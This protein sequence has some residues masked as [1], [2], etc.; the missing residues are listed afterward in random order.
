M[1]AKKQNVK[2]RQPIDGAELAAEEDRRSRGEVNAR[3]F[4]NGK[5]LKRSNRVAAIGL[6]TTDE[7]RK[8][9]DRLRLMT[10]KSYAEIFEAAL[11][12]F[13]EKW[14]EENQ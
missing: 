11:D 7:K 9:F 3:G 2:Y 6:K 5:R 14:K 8:Q 12:A 13:E 10:A 4:L 1:T